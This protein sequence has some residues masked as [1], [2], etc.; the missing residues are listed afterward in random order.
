MDFH[1]RAQPARTARGCA[2]PR[3]RAALMR[4]VL[5]AIALVA[6]APSAA[7]ATGIG[8]VSPRQGE[9]HVFARGGDGHL[10][11]SH[12][13]RQ[14]RWT[15]WA[16]LGGSLHPD[17]EISAI[18]RQDR[19]MS[20]YVRWSDNT[21]RQLPYDERGTGFGSWQNLGGELSGGPGA[22][23]LGPDRE[24]T[25]HR[26]NDGAIY[27]RGWYTASG[28]TNWGRLGEWVQPNQGPTASSRANGY[29]DV[30]FAGG[31]RSLY[32][33]SFRPD[34]G[35]ID[36]YSKGGVLTSAPG[37]ASIT[38]GWDNRQDYIA[39][40]TDN[41][42]H[43]MTYEGGR[44]IGWV[45]LGAPGVK[46]GST[47]ATI[48]WRDW[49]GQLRQ[50][51]FVYT[52]AGNVTQRTWLPG[53]GW[54]PWQTDLKPLSQVDPEPFMQ[55]PC[56]APQSG[57]NAGAVLGLSIGIEPSKI[58][59][60]PAQLRAFDNVLR[61]FRQVSGGRT[62]GIRV[63]IPIDANR[64]RPANDPRPYN[65]PAEIAAFKQLLDRAG[66]DAQGVV[67]IIG[68]DF[69]ECSAPGQITTLGSTVQGDTFPLKRC[70]IP[71]V[72][73]YGQLFG[74][75]NHIVTYGTGR[76][77]IR[78]TA[79]NEPDHKYFQ[80]RFAPKPNSTYS[81][82]QTGAWWAGRYATQVV[83]FVGASRLL[84]GEFAGSSQS[85]VSAYNAGAGTVHGTWS[86]HPYRDM[87]GDVTTFPTLT[88]FRSYVGNRDVWLTEVGP[89]ASQAYDE[90][91]SRTAGAAALG[92]LQARATKLFLYQLTTAGPSNAEPESALTDDLGRARPVLCG[93]G[94]A[95]GS[96]CRGIVAQGGG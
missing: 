58:T 35:W 11:W 75:L 89:Y 68:H 39:L 5:A 90:T 56:R 87:N 88:D 32:V 41:A 53:T 8:V 34:L 79:W 85:R 67:S 2:P 93:L 59:N 3:W 25:F 29:V 14:G 78:Y 72:G 60:N 57:I 15:N 84:A 55:G 46:P 1:S 70:Q 54:L 26:G 43:Q 96:L 36:S 51:I 6:I 7:S 44:Y 28:W 83:R 69:A 47:P 13:T 45:N 95:T 48:W 64:T 24:E 65:G 12:W 20:V 66:P 77:N 91:R 49:D 80:L 71:S 38:G 94:S 82:E 86:L 42:V 16:D 4:L 40:G 50:D 74:E 23:A 52:A 9:I 73:A 37:S 31:D 76:F 62:P 18:S 19:Y 33:K 92:Q 63:Q 21:M 17:T 30:S 10:L 22:A 61:C 27:Q 81:Q